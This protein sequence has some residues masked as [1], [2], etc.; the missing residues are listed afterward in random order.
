MIEI[1]FSEGDVKGFETPLKEQMEAPI[2]HFEKELATLR[3]GRASIALIEH[4][5]NNCR[6]HARNWNMGTGP[7][8]DKHGQCE[9]DF[10]P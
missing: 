8:H 7:E 1:S 6:I 3:T 9:Q 4:L 5:F 2:K 10:L